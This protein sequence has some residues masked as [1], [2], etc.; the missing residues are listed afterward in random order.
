MLATRGQESGQQV[1][2]N[3]DNTNYLPAQAEVSQADDM[4]ELEY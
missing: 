3:T 1:N 2:E 4:N